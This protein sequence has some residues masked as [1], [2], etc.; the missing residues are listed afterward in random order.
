MQDEFTKFV[1]NLSMIKLIIAEHDNHT[2]DMITSTIQ[3]YC[4]NVMIAST[5]SGYKDLYWSHKRT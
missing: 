5:G 3:T 1:E 2:L 4:P